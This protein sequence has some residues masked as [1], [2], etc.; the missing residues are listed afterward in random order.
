MFKKVMVIDDN[1]IDLYI[2][3]R[4][5][6]KYAFAEETILMESAANAL[7]YLS[8]NA[9]MLPQLV[10]LDINM[11]EMNGFEFL[12]SYANFPEQIKKNCVVI[13]LTTS[14]NTED[15][16]KVNTNPYVRNYLNKPLSE[17]KLN[18]LID[19]LNGILTK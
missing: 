9:D 13:M 18:W 3:K 1:E 16:E 2:A 17:E 19:F 12:D 4:V 11:P 6:K 5:I 7:E 8:A 14:A 15:Q 10:F